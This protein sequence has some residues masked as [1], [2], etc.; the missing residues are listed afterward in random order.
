[1]SWFNTGYGQTNSIAKELEIPKGLDRFWMKTGE[2]KE[3]LFLHNDP[4]RIEE[5]HPILPDKY[6]IYFTL[7]EEIAA[8][9]ELMTAFGGTAGV[10]RSAV[11]SVVDCSAQRKDANGQLKPVPALKLFVAPSQSMK[12][13]AIENED[14]KSAGKEGIVG[15]I[16]TVRRSADK[17]ARVGDNFKYSR[18]PEQAA[19]FGVTQ[20]RG[21]LLSQW[22]DEAEADPA[23]MEKLEK[24]LV[25][26]R[27]SD[28]TLDRTRI[29]VINLKEQLKPL[30]VARLKAI[31]RAHKIG[32]KV[33]AA[34]TT[35]SAGNANIG[36]EED[37]P[38]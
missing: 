11:W 12:L 36:G 33:L 35:K 8:D 38:F 21:K 18:T 37:V 14:A 7:S 1:M 2:K 26:F 28:G 20:F 30:T 13:L 17:V 23:A 32:A 15:S 34:S 5:V 22:Y 9:P 6:D 27:N 24:F 3:V 29:P 19:V 16:F 10:K 25:P 31:V 4:A